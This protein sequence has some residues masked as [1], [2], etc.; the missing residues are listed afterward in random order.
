[1]FYFHRMWIWLLGL[2]LACGLGV[3]DTVTSS[4]LVGR[5]STIGIATETL[6][7]TEEVIVTYVQG[8]PTTYTLEVYDSTTATWPD[9]S[10]PLGG[11]TT[12]VSLE[13]VSVDYLW[14]S[15]GIGHFLGGYIC[16]LYSRSHDRIKLHAVQL[17][18][19]QLRQREIFYRNFLRVE[20]AGLLWPGKLGFG[21]FNAREFCHGLGIQLFHRQ[22][23]FV[24]NNNK[25]LPVGST[26]HPRTDN[27]W[28]P[29]NRYYFL[30]DDI[31]LRYTEHTVL[32]PITHQW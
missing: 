17:D 2:L 4:A 16:H 7:W 8:T 11:L 23:E 10:L 14:I 30:V 19:G 32:A 6:I 26:S 27:N 3:S 5:V 15:H 21:I 13:L 20:F 29:A 24:Y 9:P 12:T 31:H 1:M 18:P 25:L 22:N 28:H